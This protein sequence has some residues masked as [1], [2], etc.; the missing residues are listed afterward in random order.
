MQQNEVIEVH[1][2]QE[3]SSRGLFEEPKPL[4]EPHSPVILVERDDFLV[5]R[6]EEDCVIHPANQRALA[7]AAEKAVRSAFPSESFTS[8]TIRVF[9]CPSA[10]ASQFDWQW[11][12]K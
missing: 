5:G 7:E 4:L 2:N 9:T 8:N 10:I 3:K 1:F 6:W 11:S 12:K